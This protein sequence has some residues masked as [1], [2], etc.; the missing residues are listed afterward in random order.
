MGLCNDNKKGQSHKILSLGS[1]KFTNFAKHFAGGLESS[2]EHNWAY[3]AIFKA[4]V[5][6]F[7]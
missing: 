1:Q 4:C 6:Y 5:R 3:I 7:L 2:R